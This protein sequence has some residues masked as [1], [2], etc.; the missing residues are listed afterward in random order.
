MPEK[1]RVEIKQRIDHYLPIIKD[2]ST[3]KDE[4]EKAMKA[5]FD[6][7]E[8]AIVQLRLTRSDIRVCP[9]L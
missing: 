7:D 4:R 1:F 8:L 5:W 3:P 2:V 9:S 6:G